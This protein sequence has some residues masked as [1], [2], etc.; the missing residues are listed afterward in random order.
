M[1]NERKPTIED[2]ARKA[3]V[4]LMTVSRV[5]NN[6]ASVK[7][8]TR[9]R[10]LE[11][12]AETGYQQNEA[13][14]LLRGRRARMVGII[15]PDI[16][17]AFFAACAHTI[18]QIART[19]QCMTL[20]VS[21]ER[22]ADL[23]LQEAELMGN[24]KVS[25]LLI[26][27]SILKA[28]KRFRDLQESG[29]AIVA[30]DRPLVGINTDAVLVE[31]RQGAE[32]AVRHLIEHGHHKIACVGYD[33][34]FYTVRERIEGYTSAMEAAGLT[35]NILPEMPEF[36]DIQKWAATLAK[37]KGRPTAIFSLN[38]RTSADLVRAFAKVHLVIPKDIALIGFDDFDL[39]EVLTS[40]L[41]VI[42]QSPIEMAR[43]ATSLLFEQI[44]S[45]S[46][47]ERIPAK[48]LLPVQLIIRA[49]CGCT[50]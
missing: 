11:A 43:R 23:E 7:E 46:K 34:T 17:D 10:V 3:G 6:V 50:Q 35:P 21:S 31:N 19:H 39:A 47:T 22:D 29:I 15:V 8:P 37:T 2:V 1:A 48:I 41:T 30:F 40:P 42:T 20:V 24:R 45:E 33:R 27:T 44:Q 32:M 9:Q 12:I 14:R 28:N 36:E 18:Q 4:S 49:S 25:G 5:V 16:S 13:G 26:A 38:H